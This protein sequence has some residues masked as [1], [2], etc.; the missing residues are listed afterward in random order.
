VNP[1]SDHFYFL[2]SVEGLYVGIYCQNSFIL[3]LAKIRNSKRAGKVLSLVGMLKNWLQLIA[4]PNL[5]FN[6]FFC[7]LFD[8]HFSAFCPYWR[9]GCHRVAIGL[10]YVYLSEPYGNPKECLSKT[11]SYLKGKQVE[12]CWMCIKK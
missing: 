11:T 6:W 9:G 3:E 10:G 5:R 2:W 4:S 1:G 12:V 7:S 8:R